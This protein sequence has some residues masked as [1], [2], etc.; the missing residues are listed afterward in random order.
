MKSLEDIIKQIKKNLKPHEIKALNQIQNR[1]LK[2]TR[3][4]KH[5]MFKLQNSKIEF[6]KKFRNFPLEIDSQTINYTP[7]FVLDFPYENRIRIIIEVHEDLTDFDV[8]KYRTFMDVY[9]RVYWL[10]ISSSDFMCIN[11]KN[12]I[13]LL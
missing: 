6:E 10:I 13:Y 11:T 5:V 8:K 2:L 12:I 4:E 1:S 9:G 3:W 7:D